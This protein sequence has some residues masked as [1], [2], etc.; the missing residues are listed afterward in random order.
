MSENEFTEIPRDQAEIIRDVET[1]AFQLNTALL[2]YRLAGGKLADSSG[3][4]LMFN[5]TELFLRERGL[6]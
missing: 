4:E 6:V 2:Q 1:H 5:A 3:I